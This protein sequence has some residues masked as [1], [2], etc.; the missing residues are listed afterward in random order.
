MDRAPAPALAAPRRRTW[1]RPDAQRWMT[2]E[3]RKWL[4]PERKQAV[5]QRQPDDHGLDLAAEREWLRRMRGELASL[6]AELKL[7][8]FF[9]SLKAGFIPSQPRDDRGRWTDTG[10]EG[11][12]ND[13]GGGEASDRESDQSDPNLRVA[14]AGFGVLV[15]ELSRRG[16]RDCVYRFFGSALLWVDQRT[17]GVRTRCIGLP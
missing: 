10:G 13:A 1:L 16:G 15:V 17:F 4:L 11:A 3:E 12:G 14:D 7:R 9:R 2:P 5:A 6:K 8:Q